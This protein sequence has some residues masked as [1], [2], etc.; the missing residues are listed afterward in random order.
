VFDADESVGEATRD[1]ESPLL[2]TPVALALVESN[3]T[4]TP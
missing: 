3:W 1:A 2:E 4:Q